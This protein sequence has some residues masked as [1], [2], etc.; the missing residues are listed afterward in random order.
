MSAGDYLFVQMSMN[1]ANAIT[2]FR[3]LLI[4]MVVGIYFLSGCF[5]MLLRQRCLH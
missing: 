2:S 5:Q 3:L 4:P 1:L